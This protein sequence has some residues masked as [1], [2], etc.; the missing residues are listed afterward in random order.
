MVHPHATLKIAATALLLA[1]MTVPSVLAGSPPYVPQAVYPPDGATDV[2]LYLE[3]SEGHLDWT[4]GDPDGDPVVYYVYFGTTPS[5]G[6]AGASSNTQIVFMGLPLVPGETYYWQVLADSPDT[7]TLSD[8]FTF[9]MWD[10]DEWEC[11]DVNYN[12]D[13]SPDISDLLY[14]VGYMFHGGYP[15]VPHWCTA[16][17]N[18][19]GSRDISDIT[20]FVNW[21]F[22]GGPPPCPWCCG[23]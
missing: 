7:S 13:L 6:Y 3:G 14:L 19:D 22:G 18:C 11:G 5:M 12:Q 17:V 1:V 8:I 15:P 21:M 4:G 16:D 2:P 20:Y 10:V 9:T 23:G